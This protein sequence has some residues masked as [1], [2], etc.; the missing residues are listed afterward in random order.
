MLQ[1]VS[2]YNVSYNIIHNIKSTG[3]NSFTRSIV[4][5]AHDKTYMDTF[6]DYLENDFNNCEYK[7]II[8]NSIC[9][10]GQ[11]ALMIAASNGLYKICE[12]MIKYGAD[13]YY[14]TIGYTILDYVMIYFRMH[15]S[16]DMIDLFLKYHVSFKIS[17]ILWVPKEIFK[18]IIKLYNMD[19]EYII[20]KLYE[21]HQIKPNMEFINLVNNS[22]YS[23]DCIKLVASQ[24]YND[25]LKCLFVK[26]LCYSFD[27]YSSDNNID[28]LLN[29]YRTSCRYDNYI[30]DIIN[31]YFNDRNIKLQ[32]I[33]NM[34]KKQ[35]SDTYTKIRDR[36]III[37]CILDCYHDLIKNF[38]TVGQFIEHVGKFLELDYISTLNY[39]TLNDKTI[40]IYNLMIVGRRCKTSANKIVMEILALCYQNNVISFLAHFRGYSKTMS[41]ELF[42]LM[43]QYDINVS[44]NMI[45]NMY[46]NNKMLLNTVKYFEYLSYYCMTKHNKSLEDVIEVERQDMDK[47][48]LHK[49]KCVLIQKIC[50]QYPMGNVGCMDTQFLVTLLLSLKM[51]NKGVSYVLKKYVLCEY[52]KV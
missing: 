44:T 21:Q 23:I 50:G 33:A 43:V 16:A 1:H 3:I 52:F 31:N 35:Y 17:S 26:L 18:K 13:V 41:Y 2:N 32:F 47:L 15:K 30:G 34:E 8:V 5:S 4:K 42:L 10:T 40:G 49:S 20:T 11:S 39:F 28:E 7:N 27:Q 46:C 51:L 37:S 29:F 38:M 36:I 45:N 25:D 14:K 9:S 22:V 6:I 48:H 19:L 12:L 24:H